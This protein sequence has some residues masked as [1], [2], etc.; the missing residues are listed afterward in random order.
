VKTVAAFGLALA[1][2]SPVVAHAQTVSVSGAAYLDASRFKSL[3]VFNPTSD[4]LVNSATGT[5]SGGANFTG[6]STKVGGT[7]LVVF[8][9]SS[10]TLSTNVTITFNLD[11]VGPSVAFLSR[12]DMRIDGSIDVS[13]IGLAGG[14][15][16]GDF[17]DGGSWGGKYGGGGGGY[18]GAGGLGGGG[19]PAGGV[20]NPDLTTQLIGGSSGGFGG[21]TFVDAAH[22]GAGGGALQLCALGSLIVNGAISANGGYGYGIYGG[23]GVGGGGAGSGG[24]LLIQAGSVILTSNSVLSVNGGEGGDG[25]EGDQYTSAYGGGGGGG[26]RILIAY[27]DSET[28]TGTVTALGGAGGNN[29]GYSGAAGNGGAG[30]VTFLKDARVPA[31]VALGT[32]TDSSGNLNLWWPA[33]A[34]NYVLQMT[35]S[36]VGGTTW[37]P[38]QGA[39]LSGKDF[40]F[41][42]QP[43]NGTSFFRLVAH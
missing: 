36:L 2:T 42:I 43:S 26:G 34:T 33:N 32:F 8:T 40:N 31:L 9:F 37:T 27:A 20:Y 4:V 5:M 38:V 1:L 18:G 15:G 30:S 6:I 19:P 23:D 3:G 17:A 41:T 16:S 11:T 14:P 21:S 29:I 22:G 13:A 25:A 24:G 35:S 7:Q 28:S 12:C 10:F 39:A